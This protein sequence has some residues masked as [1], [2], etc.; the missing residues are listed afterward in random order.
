MARSK[1]YVGLSKGER[2]AFS[3]A[4]VPAECN[5]GKLYQA[6]IGPF[7]TRRGAE[8][9]AKFGNN[10]PHLQTVADAERQALSFAGQSQLCADY[11]KH[12]D[13]EIHRNRK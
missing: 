6:V 5:Y 9:M 4:V 11:R 7:R 2:T 1:W 13:N 3:S 8:H 12:L 10:N